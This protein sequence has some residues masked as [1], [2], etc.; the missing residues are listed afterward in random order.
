MID[1]VKLDI[2]LSLFCSCQVNPLS[3]TILK[4]I[5]GIKRLKEMIS[6]WI[7]A[8]CIREETTQA[9]QNGIKGKVY[10]STSADSLCIISYIDSVRPF[11]QRCAIWMIAL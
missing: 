11:R 6:K 2:Q 7:E 9:S 1:A 3:P 8:Q 4:H 5:F 10:K